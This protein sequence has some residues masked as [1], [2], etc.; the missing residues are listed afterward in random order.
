MG[1]NEQIDRV[2]EHVI[3]WFKS[4][5]PSP[6]PSP[7]RGKHHLAAF[8]LSSASDCNQGWERLSLSPR[9]RAGVRGKESV[10]HLTTRESTP[11]LIK[12]ALASRHF[13]LTVFTRVAKHLRK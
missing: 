1:L 9:E 12:P 4:W 8:A 3:G 13:F 10:E 2:P 6:Y 11:I 5:S 7:R